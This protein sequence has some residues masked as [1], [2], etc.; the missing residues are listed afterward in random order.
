MNL[1]KQNG[2]RLPGA[3]FVDLA[4]RVKVACGN[5]SSSF[6]QH[7]ISIHSISINHS[8]EVCGPLCGNPEYSAREDRLR[9]HI[10]WRILPRA[11]RTSSGEQTTA[12]EPASM[13]L[14]LHR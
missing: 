14:W 9:V 12:H 3:F 13:A 8:S 10:S 11:V 5:A 2:R 7:R 4:R 1:G 6:H